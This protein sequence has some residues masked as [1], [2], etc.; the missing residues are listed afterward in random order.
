ML[1]K[2]PLKDL[3]NLVDSASSVPQPVPRP[4]AVKS[5][6]KKAKAK[7]AVAEF[8]SLP[9]AK[10]PTRTALGSIRPEEPRTASEENRHLAEAL[11]A[12]GGV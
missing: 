9:G 6:E 8:P 11:R 10:P 2:G 7:A 12:S 3:V 5:S 4:S 1:F